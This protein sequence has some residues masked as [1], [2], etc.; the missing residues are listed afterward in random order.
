[1]VSNNTPRRVWDFGIKHAAKF[2]SMITSVKLNG[3]TPVEAV[4]G[5]TPGILEYIYFYLY[6]L[7]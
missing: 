2:I 1:M 4:M 3:R 5:E 7:V 6:D